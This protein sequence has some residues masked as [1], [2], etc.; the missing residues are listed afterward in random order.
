MRRVI[1]SVVLFALVALPSPAQEKDAAAEIGS[2]IKQLELEDRR[3]AAIVELAGLGRP[4]AEALLEAL[5]SELGRDRDDTAG[6]MIRALGAL[7]ELAIAAKTKLEELAEGKNQDLARLAGRAL[8]SMRASGL[9]LIADY[10]DNCLLTVDAS[11]KVTHRIEEVFG[12]WDVEILPNGNH[13]V[14][15]FSVSRVTEMTVEGNVVWRFTNLKNPYDAD[16]LPNGNTLI[17]DT[18]G[19]R[20]IEVDR[21]GQIVWRYDVGIRPFDVDRLD[22]GNTLIADVIQD[23]VLEVN[24]KGEIVWDLGNLPNIHDADRLPNGNTLITLRTVNRV[25]ELDPKGQEVFRLEGLNSP[26][27]ADRLPNGNTLVAENGGVREFDAQGKVVWQ[28][29]TKWAVEVNRY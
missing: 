23:R 5:Q 16:R 11:G 9:T 24:P 26:S 22:N 18:F 2:L 3:E 6:A 15:E 29:K 27:D 28:F 7:G 10:S 14:T 13:L 17:A 25:L 4:A 1:Q 20:V 21:Q 12:A 19:G 8:M